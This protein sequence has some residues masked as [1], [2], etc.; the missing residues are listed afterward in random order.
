MKFTS[1]I[2]AFF[3]SVYVASVL[4]WPLQ[5]VHA[6]LTALPAIETSKTSLAW[7]DQGY[8]A[9][10]S[11]ADGV[12]AQSS[13]TEIPVPIASITKIITAL[14][15]LE[16]KPLGAGE[17]GPT[18]TLTAADAARYGEYLAQNGSVASAPV[19][20]QVTQRQMLEA[21][22]IV[23]ANN[24]ADSLALW[25]YG[26][27]EAYF[28]A[29]NTLLNKYKLTNT[30]VADMTGFSPDSKSTPSDLIRLGELALKQP[31][32]A[33]IVSQK[34]VTIPGVGTL[35]NTN[36][37]LGTEGIQGMK[38][39]TTDEAGSCLLFSATHQ[40]G[41]ETI[42]IIGVVLGAPNHATLFNQVRTLLLS[43]KPNFQE[44]TLLKSN[45]Q[46]GEYRTAWG[47]QSKAIV[48][49]SATQVIW[50]DEK[51][52]QATSLQ[53]LHPGD[54]KAGSVTSKIAGKTLTTSV[55]LDEELVGPSW[56][57]RLTH[58]HEIF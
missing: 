39:G 18:I 51:I 10:G 19:G 4:L 6:R 34:T 37:L 12:L 8:A 33:E 42:T 26:T 57:W 28:A 5:T 38:T 43:V 54:T 3:T 46:V 24:Y 21:M 22:L 40:V 27:P 41:T 36:I 15:V 7:P 55:T 14:T 47:A 9:I 2:I 44:A 30:S 20:L 58:P 1:G 48:K 49:N 52:I 23:S 35:Q 45:Q 50:G 17:T 53:S 56:H 11:T 32:I 13:P 25:A 29:A 16:A 31:V